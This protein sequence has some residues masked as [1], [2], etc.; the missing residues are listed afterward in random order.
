M[1]DRVLCQCRTAQTHNVET[2]TNPPTS[3]VCPPNFTQTSPAPSPSRLTAESQPSPRPAAGRQKTLLVASPSFSRAAAA[4]VQLHTRLDSHCLTDRP[5]DRPAGRQSR[6]RTHALSFLR[7]LL[8]SP[9]LALSSGQKFCR[10][11][12]GASAVL[13]HRRQ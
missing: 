1:V 6:T 7:S 12:K 2:P 8:L 11:V 4:C 5:T 10:V 13:H 3:S 9:H